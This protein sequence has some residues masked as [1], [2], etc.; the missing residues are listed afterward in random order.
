VG[1]AIDVDGVDVFGAF[2]DLE[3]LQ[4]GLRDLGLPPLDLRITPKGLHRL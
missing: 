3:V 4:D 2:A 1:Y